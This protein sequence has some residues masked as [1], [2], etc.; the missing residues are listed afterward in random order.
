MKR[1]LFIVTYL[2]T[3]GI[4]KALQ[5]FLSS[6][7]QQ[8]YLVDVFSLSHQGAFSKSLQNCNLLPKDVLVHC[9]ISRFKQL[10][11]ESRFLSIFMKV[12]NRILRNKLQSYLFKKLA[13]K[14]EKANTY[15][16][17]IGFSEGIPTIFA[18]NFK[19]PNKIGWIHCDY[20][21]IHSE[22]IKNASYSMYENMKHIVCVSEYTKN[23]FLNLFP[24]FL[25]K[26]TC[27]HNIV[28]SY[29]ICSLANE[30]QEYVYDSQYFNIVSVGRIDPVKR[31]SYIPKVV[32]DLLN[33]KHNV[34][35]YIVGPVAIQ[36]EY[37]LLL[38]NIIKYDVAESVILVG[39]QKN[40]YPYIANADIF[41]STSLSE[42]CPY[43]V[44]EAKILHKPIVCTNFG[45][46][47][48]FISNGKDGY[49]STLENLANTIDYLLSNPLVFDKLKTE[50]SSFN[51]D[52]AKILSKIENLLS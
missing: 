43:V 34:R 12:L 20:T 30:S 5:N 17:V 21:N 45:S 16:A 9:L 1:I 35:W 28:D 44:N 50:I 24:S 52:N 39:E 33:K 7:N 14:L 32:R 29:S 6:Y 49:I 48:E 26:T 4:T 42:A 38:S 19:C 36:S 51:Y 27:I 18:S 2:D 40:P 46:V 10:P 41:V 8:D 23:T 22:S 37:N 11:N 3:G 15:D 25:D 31:F 13:T 47:Y